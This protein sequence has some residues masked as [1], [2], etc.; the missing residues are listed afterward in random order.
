MNEWMRPEYS[1]LQT[2]SKVCYLFWCALE[3]PSETQKSSHLDADI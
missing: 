1:A 3:N 2:D